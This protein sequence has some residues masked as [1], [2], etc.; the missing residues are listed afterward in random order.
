MIEFYMS[1]AGALFTV[2]AALLAACLSWRFSKG[3]NA[4]PAYRIG[5]ISFATLAVVAGMTWDVVRTSITMA[6]LCPQAGIHIKKTAKVDGFYTNFGSPD[7]LER[8]FKYIE[9]RS[10]G[11]RLVLYSKESG[12]VKKQ[13]F[14]SKKYKIKSR[15]EFI[16]GTESGAYMGRQDIGVRKSVVR[17]RASNEELG[18]ALGYI[19]YPGW[20]DQKTVG[21]ISRFVW[22]CK[23]EISG[24]DVIVYQRVLLP[25]N[26]VSK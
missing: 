11:D 3:I 21:L 20:L 15:Y 5:I 1:A 4:R 9:S 10:Y 26:E 19:A 7:M 14:D 6:Q 8:G 22:G 12:V 17:D 23:S 16:Y 13:E 18:Y 25:N 24:Q 2:I